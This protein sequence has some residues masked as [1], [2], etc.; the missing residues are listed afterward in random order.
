LNKLPI[1][2]YNRQNVLVIAKELLGKLITTNIDDRT[3]IGRIV[4]T[5][6]YAGLQ[7]GH[8]MPGRVNAQRATSIC[9]KHRDGLCVHLLWY[10]PAIQYRYQ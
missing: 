9:M 5:E 7:I 8:R 4:E 2:F 6:A 1:D 3:T 10:T